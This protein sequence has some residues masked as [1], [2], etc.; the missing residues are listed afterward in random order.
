MTRGTMPPQHISKTRAAEPKLRV[1]PKRRQIVDVRRKSFC[2][3]LGFPGCA[4]DFSDDC[5]GSCD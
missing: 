4:V 3:P 1:I 5:A 2:V